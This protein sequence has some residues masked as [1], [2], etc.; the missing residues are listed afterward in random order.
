MRR[1]KLKKG[2]KSST[3]GVV[4]EGIETCTHHGTPL[5]FVGALVSCSACGSTGRIVAQGPRWIDT[6]MGKE[7]ALEGDLCLCK[8]HPTPVMV[9]SQDTAFHSFESHELKEKGFGPTGNPLVDDYKGAFDE[10]VRILDEEGRPLCGVP[11]HI[12]TASGA[13]FKGLTDLSGYCPRVYTKDAQQLNIAVG[14]KAL[15][16][17]TK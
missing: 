4:T 9:A 7:A 1:N 13:T 2:D 15:E 16:R 17:W 8:C 6:M 3:G 14:M 12:K 5:T 10:R 11:Y